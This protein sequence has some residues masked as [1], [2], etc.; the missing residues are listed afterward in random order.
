MTLPSVQP[1]MDPERLP[2]TFI[3][4]CQAGL[5]VAASHTWTMV[6]TGVPLV[7]NP[8]A[9]LPAASRSFPDVAAANVRGPELPARCQVETIERPFLA[10]EG[11]SRQVNPAFGSQHSGGANFVMADGSVH[12]LSENINLAIYRFLGTRADG[13][14]VGSFLN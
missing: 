12:F 8:K 13:L 6:P 5:P 14:P 4:T 11:R 3:S 2:A 1:P 7:A 10:V 9:T